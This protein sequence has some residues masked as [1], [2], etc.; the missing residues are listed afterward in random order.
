[1]F[2][3]S[4]LFN[5]L[6]K[7][8]SKISSIPET[9]FHEIIHDELKK[10]NKD[11]SEDELK[12]A[13]VNHPF[14]EIV[15]GIS[16]DSK[17]YNFDYLS[18]LLRGKNKLSSH[19]SIIVKNNT[20]LF[21]EFKTG[22]CDKINH[23]TYDS[24][25]DKCPYD[26]TKPHCKD[27]WIEAKHKRNAEKLN[28]V[29]SLQLKTLESFILLQAAYPQLKTYKVKLIIVIDVG[30]IDIIESIYSDITASNKSNASVPE[31]IIE[32]SKYNPLEKVESAIMRYRQLSLIKDQNTENKNSFQLYADIRVCYISSFEKELKQLL[33]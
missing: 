4:D 21:V 32:L 16:I 7:I 17:I 3:H 22:F 20:I 9:T 19:D 2:K 27:Y 5:E 10:R 18:E 23:N 31:P 14:Y 24:A 30:P 12:D 29:K 33:K 26:G 11:A 6:I 8:N 1:M 15:K 28:L 13:L 25:E